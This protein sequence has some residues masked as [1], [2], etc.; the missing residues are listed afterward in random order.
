M[1]EEVTSDIKSIGSSLKKGLGK[2]GYALLLAGGAV[3][4][5]VIILRSNKDDKTEDYTVPTGVASYPDV[6]E[7]ADVVISSIGN[8]IDYAQDEIIDSI[9]ETIKD[10]KED[11]IENDNNNTDTIIDTIKNTNPMYTDISSSDGGVSYQ[12][13]K[14]VLSSKTDISPF[15]YNATALAVAGTL[16][17]LPVVRETLNR[18][19]LT[20]PSITGVAIEDFNRHQTPTD[21]LQPYKNS[22]L[23]NGT[24]RAIK[25]KSNTNPKTVKKTATKSNVHTS[26]STTIKKTNY[27]GNSIVDGLKSA[28]V[29]SS[30]A[31]RKKLAQ[32]NGIKN[33]TG[34][35][36]QNTKLLNSL[37]SGTLKSG[38]TGSSKS[39]GSSSK[40]SGSSSKSSGSSNRSKSSSKKKK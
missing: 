30:Y 3:L 15:E 27:K 35:T 25:K 39:S 31:N 33:Y 16:S 26:K 20:Q 29:N 8:S 17:G 1:L 38:N 7:N 40:K 36:S 12:T 9:G 21:T 34:T 13:P 28:G 32:A 19:G 22:S 24:M 23:A 2:N 37:K 14:E 6:G 5:L 10:S 18:S 11:I 4:A